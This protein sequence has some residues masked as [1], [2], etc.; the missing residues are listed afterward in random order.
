M[1]KQQSLSDELRAE[2]ET[3]KAE[4]SKLGKVPKADGTMH[5]VNDLFGPMFK[6]EIIKSLYWAVKAEK[7]VYKY[8]RMEAVLKIPALP[9]NISQLIGWMSEVLVQLSSVDVSA[10]FI[11]S[12]WWG[13]LENPTGS[14]Q[15]ELQK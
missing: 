6:P 13:M 1:E 7:K 15:D 14:E 10:S 5:D 8:S 3:I 4:M 9:G 12:E 2:T 11:L